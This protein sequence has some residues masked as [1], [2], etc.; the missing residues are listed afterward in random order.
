MISSF[1]YILK[2]D[3]TKHE[4]EKYKLDHFFQALP[5][6]Q[7][8]SAEK[9]SDSMFSIITVAVASILMMML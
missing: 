6:T 3:I 9:M 5:Q 7:G 2:K 8:S 4:Y 1:I